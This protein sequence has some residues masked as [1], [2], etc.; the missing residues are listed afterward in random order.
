MSSGE[1][2]RSLLLPLLYNDEN[3]MMS[4][5]KIFLRNSAPSRNQCIFYISGMLVLLLTLTSILCFVLSL[6]LDCGP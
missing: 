2:R 1:V 5:F 3:T 6:E 4:S